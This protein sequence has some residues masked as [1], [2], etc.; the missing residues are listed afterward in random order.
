MRKKTAFCIVVLVAVL[1]IFLAQYMMNPSVNRLLAADV[2]FLAAE[3]RNMYDFIR[4]EFLYDMDIYIALAD[5]DFDEIPEF[6]FGY[7]TLTGS[8][9]KIWYRAYSLKNH[10]LISCQRLSNWT[11]FFR[12][13]D[14]ACALYA[15]HDNFIEGYYRNDAGEAVFVTQSICGPV[16]NMWTDYLL[17]QYSDS[18][19][20]TEAVF[21]NPYE[22]TPL[23]QAFSVASLDMLQE[24]ITAL[25]DVYLQAGGI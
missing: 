3:I 7:Q 5:L 4:P 2:D 10:V 21:E 15:D 24:D 19:L 20:K 17:M 12:E 23:K 18:I 16:V 6:F 25:L 22:L 1:G 8:S 11:T 14:A 9:R 13:D